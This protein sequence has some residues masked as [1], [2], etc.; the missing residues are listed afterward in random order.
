RQQPHLRQRIEYDARRSRAIDGIQNAVR[1]LRQLD[2]RW[3]HHCQW[4]LGEQLQLLI[5]G[6]LNDFQSIERPTVRGGASLQ[7]LPCFRQRDVQ[8]LLAVLHTFEQE[9]QRKGRLATTGVAIHQIQSLRNQAPVQ[10][11]I[12]PRYASAQAGRALSNHR[13]S[14]QSC[15]SRGGRQ[16]T[17]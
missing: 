14:R 17:A 5:G 13:I 15:S 2:I 11:L 12:Q 1:S 8:A 16:L 10:N 9:L 6:Q 3:L 4:P 7:L